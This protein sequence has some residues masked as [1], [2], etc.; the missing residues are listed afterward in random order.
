MRILK[1]ILYV[2]LGLM[3]V[4]AIS[5]FVLR[6]IRANQADKIRIPK[7][8]QAMLHIKV[9]N[10]LLKMGSNSLMNWNAYYGSKGKDSTSADKVKIWGMGI[11]VP[12]HLYFFSLPG[13][14]STYYTI[15]R[16]SDFAKAKQFLTDKLG[17][18]AQQGLSASNELFFTKGDLRI[19]L[20]YSKL[21]V[22]LGKENQGNLEPMKALLQDDQQDW[23]NAKERFDAKRNSNLGDMTWQG[24]G[25]NYLS[26]KFSAGTATLTGTLASDSYRFP[27]ATKKLKTDSHDSLLVHLEINNDLSAMVNLNNLLSDS[28]SS[29]PLDSIS[30]YLGNYLSLRISNKEIT[31]V[32]SIVS[33]D[34]DDNFEMIEKKTL[35]ETQVPDIHLNIMG[36]PHLLSLV[37]EKIFYKFHKSEHAGLLNLTTAGPQ[38]GQEET[39]VPSDRVFHFYYKNSPLIGKYFAFVP[40]YEKLDYLEINGKSSQPT[41]INLI[42][43]VHFKNQDLNSFFQ[44]INF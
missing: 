37:P 5:L 8:S 33:Y 15:L 40:S 21:V 43:R 17:M 7:D 22:G 9:D 19:L 29:T 38:Q 34:Y 14:E 39:L 18:E 42:G 3:V 35:N 12:G 36:S 23:V 4:I 16:V 31:Q 24:E 27:K 11:D 32:D 1:K 44:L 28:T 6:T 20:S 30:N 13:R 25:K 41:E 26:L 10:L 2:I